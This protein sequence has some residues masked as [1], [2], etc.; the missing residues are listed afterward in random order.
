LDQQLLRVQG[1]RKLPKIVAVD[2]P[3]GSG[4]SSICSKVSRRLGWTYVNT[5]ALY[6]AIGYLAEQYKI[7]LDD[8][9]RMGKLVEEFSENLIWHSDEQKLF[10]ASQDLTPELDTVAAARNASKIAQ[11]PSLRQKLLG[12]QR[13]L[14]FKSKRGAVVDGRDI[15]TVVFPNADLKI[16][17]TASLEVRSRRRLKQIVE[18][19]TPAGM[20]G[21]P[22]ALAAM[23]EEISSRD[24]QDAERAVA[25]LMQPADAILLDTSDM[26]VEETI[27]TMIKLIQERTDR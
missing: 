4:K 18:S 15:G 8:E 14:A 23:M 19:G 16:F 11:S 22:D 26:N 10:Y 27:A 9:E 7:S 5:G 2:G 12:V 24:T 6:R 13:E 1:I 25:P 21:G 20:D 3:A 17:M